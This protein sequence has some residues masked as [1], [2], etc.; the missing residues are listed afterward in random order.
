MK[1][2]ADTRSLLFLYTNDC[3]RYLLLSLELFFDELLF[4][5]ALF[6]LLL[7][8]A[9]FFA[10]MFF[11]AYL[12][13][14]VQGYCFIRGFTIPLTNTLIKNAATACCRAYSTNDAP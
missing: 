12:I 7:L 3:F 6:L 13:M 8:L 5:G 11:L 14:H 1:F 2:I 4:F 9:D 10:A